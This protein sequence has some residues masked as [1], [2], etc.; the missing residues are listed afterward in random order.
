MSIL[1]KNKVCIEDLDKLNASQMSCAQDK[2]R[3]PAVTLS[4]IPD[5]TNLPPPASSNSK[6]VLKSTFN[7]TRAPSTPSVMKTSQDFSVPPPLRLPLHV[8]GQ[9]VP[10]VTQSQE[11]RIDMEFTSNILKKLGVFCA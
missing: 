3:K 4:S 5:I 2:A 11:T 9:S 1:I 7:V 8:H 10:V 6:K